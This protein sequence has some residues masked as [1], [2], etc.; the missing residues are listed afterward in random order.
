MSKK[1]FT[2][3]ALLALSQA[4]F[5]AWNGSAKI[6][7]AVTEDGLTTYEITSPEE[8]I[9]FLDSIV[10]VN[11]ANENLRAYLKNDI[12]FGDD[13]TKLSDKRWI[14]NEDQD[15][16]MG[17]FDGKNHTIYGL[18][19]EN[20][21]FR[22]VGQS[23]G[24]V[25]DLNIANSSFGSDSAY[26]VAAIAD[27]LHGFALN[28][29]II[30]TDVVATGYAGGIAARLISSEDVFIGIFNCNVE[31]GSVGGGMYVGGIVG[32]LVGRVFN[33]TNSAR[34]YFAD[35]MKG[36][37]IS[38][39]IGGI[40]GTAEIRNG[41]VLESCVNRGDIEVTGT[42]FNMSVGGL[43]GE[44][45]GGAENL[46]NYGN[47]TVKRLPLAST[48][49]DRMEDFILVGGIT[50]Y[51]SRS[52][53][54]STAVADLLNEGN[55]NVSSEDTT[56][57]GTIPVGGIVG[58]TAKTGVTNVL[59][60]GSIEVRSGAEMIDVYAGGIIGK[61]PMQ[62]NPDGFVKVKN[63]GSVYAEGAGNTYAGGL[64]G[65]MN[66]FPNAKYP[67]LRESFNYGD[68][69]AKCSDD[70][71]NL[72]VGGILGSMV[73]MTVSDVYNRG[74]V[75]TKGNCSYKYVGGILGEGS[76]YLADSIKNAYSA[77]ANV[78]GG[79]MT[80]ALVG[81]LREIT[82]PFNTYFDVSLADMSAIGDVDL[83]GDCPECKK[84]SAELKS[85]EMLASLNTANGTAADRQ[86]WVRRGGYP[87]LTFDSVYKNDS[88]YFNM[89]EFVIPPSR[90]EQDTLNFTIST[91]EEMRTFL[92]IG[93][94]FYG[95]YFKVE[96]ANDIVMGE[97]SLHL[98]M[99]KVSADT[100]G[101][102]VSLQFDGKGH[103]VYGLDMERSMFHCLDTN[104]LVQNLTI[105]NSRFENNR[106]LSA[107]GLAIL[108]DGYVRNV[109]IRNSLVRSDDAAAG[110]VVFNYKMM[111]DLKNV[112][113]SVYSLGVAGGLVAYSYE[114]VVSGAANSG[115]VSGLVAGGIVGSA[116]G[117]GHGLNVVSKASNTGT[118]LVE[119]DSVVVGGGIVGYVLRT[120]LS[121]SLN[122]GLVQGSAD[123]DT[124][125]LGGIVGKAD[126]ISSFSKM[127]NWGRVHV[128][129]ANRA[130]AGGLVGLFSGRTVSSGSMLYHAGGFTQSFNYG[131]VHVV[132]SNDSSYAGG[133]IG[134]ANNIVLQDAYNRGVIKNEGNTQASFTG[135]MIGG[136]T[137]LTL[138]EGY[139]FTDTL[140]GSG[141]G[142]LVY[143]I[144][145]KR[146]I[147]STLYY[148][149]EKLTSPAVAELL[150]D[151]S[152]IYE[153]IEQKSFEEMKGRLA[154]L[155]EA[156]GMWTLGNCLPKLPLDT[157][158]TCEVNVV[159]DFFEE[160]FA[161]S[162]PYLLDVVYAPD[163][164]SGEE[165][166]ADTTSSEQHADTTSHE[167]HA[168][169]TSSGEK[170]DPSHV[171]PKV[172]PLPLHIGVHERDITVSGLQQGYPVLV[173]D[174]RG[175]L[176]VSARAHNAEVKLSV[177]HAGRYLVRSGKRL[178]LVNI[179]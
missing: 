1:W 159:K 81:Y 61:A 114:A 99:R 174:L 86:L 13:T 141:V 131:P 25:R 65:W 121:E 98:M 6:P 158:M 51:L 48:D 105:A 11:K 155:E 20:S 77:A 7:E 55:I 178:A 29:N 127:G 176:V 137:F 108:N 144:N 172:K 10:P 122:S 149:D 103:T 49:V 109:T 120:S 113:T 64:V 9:G 156:G 73:V 69:Q 63:R 160:G 134:Y 142:A 92:E 101:R 84:T 164:T 163:T 16:F 97:D 117:F 132:A 75:S 110:L 96:L 41:S 175:R 94:I 165:Q 133:I 24:T 135:G 72:K 17:V 54:F 171:L 18:N 80:G 151:Q 68:V 71:A 167:E 124:I 23:A 40:A 2:L 38:V 3:C 95:K 143:A 15:L 31:G 28:V 166:H 35:N 26:E 145:G 125:A 148:G 88:V 30:N 170:E 19:A 42:H 5:A 129:S 115:K 56:V 118:I 87:V 70:N 4:S 45:S 111:L 112:N 27:Y 79:E 146:N 67:Q 39:F 34:V 153:D 52:S 14:R 162:V 90:I 22:M 58:Q 43:A 102:C 85:D 104:A 150:N 152:N 93:R 47:I 21:L 12:V 91:A 177:P 57:R 33:S 116:T 169:T 37:D 32:Q 46:Q 62:I 82:M 138:F 126:S 60:R 50:G 83:R 74:N 78:E 106:G 59:N 76:G 100:S 53:F 140:T 36:D 123:S 119:G 66:G 44:I 173:F 168:D 130:Y 89:E 136:A 147:V 8:L 161:D 107:A 157:T 154:F 139:S 128:I 179:R